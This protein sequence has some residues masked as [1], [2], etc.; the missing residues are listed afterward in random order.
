MIAS[1]PVA[2][3]TLVAPS[4]KVNTQFFHV[5]APSF[6]V[7]QLDTASHVNCI[8]YTPKERMDIRKMIIDSNF[9]II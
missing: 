2:H 5:Q 7:T 8:A 9:F 4:L 3:T 1:L 6:I